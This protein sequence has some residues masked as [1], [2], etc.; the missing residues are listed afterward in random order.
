M[1]FIRF[2]AE[3]LKCSNVNVLVGLTEARDG[4]AVAPLD[5]CSPDEHAQRVVPSVPDAT[6]ERAATTLAAASEPGR[7][8]LLMVLAEGGATVGVIAKRLGVRLSH[9]SQRLAVL[10]AAR[11]VR[12]KRR[13]KQVEYSLV[14]DHIHE[15][16]R[17]A[18]ALA[19]ENTKGTR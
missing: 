1:P 12:A 2:L 7:L 17:L 8:R 9:A 4:W 18:L 6:L 19:A 15:L 10:R 3:S 5:P 16:V 14:D 11:L 13:G